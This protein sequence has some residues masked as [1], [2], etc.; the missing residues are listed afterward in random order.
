[1]LQEIERYNVLLKI[2]KN[3]LEDL[4]K[5]ILGLVVMSG[6]LEEAFNCIYETRVPPLWENAYSSLKPLAAW[7]RDMVARVEQ[8]AGWAESAHPPHIF[9]MSG[10]TFPT[11]FLTAVLQFSARQNAVPVDS[12]SWEFSVFTVDDNNITSAP[13]DGVYIKGLYLEGA[14]WDKKAACLVEANPMQLTTPIPTI[15]FKPT[16]AR[17][18]QAK[19]FFACPTYYYPIRSTS[20]VVSVDL[21]AGT[22]RLLK[23]IPK[24]IHWT[25]F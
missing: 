9:W 22:F 17:K 24:K 7:T 12:L 6:D 10:F 3:S 20:F 16:E 18:K 21:K 19:G 5:A 23:N 13:Q 25:V 15:H 1:M 4:K 8:L 11:G 2:I 14:G